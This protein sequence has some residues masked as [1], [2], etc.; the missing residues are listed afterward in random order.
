LHGRPGEVPSI[1]P[2]MPCA[3][4]ACTQSRNVWRSMPPIRA[5]ALRLTPSR[6]P[7]S[8]NSR[9]A[10]LASLDAAAA[11]LPESVGVQLDAITTKI[12]RESDLA[13]SKCR[14]HS[15]VILS[16]GWYNTAF[17]GL[18]V[19]LT[20]AT[21]EAVAMVLYEFVT[22]AVKY[23]ALSTPQGRVS[24]TWVGGSNG[25]LS[26]GIVIKWRKTGSPLATPPKRSGYGTSLIR[27]LIP[28]EIGGA[29]DLAFTA[30]GL[31]CKIK[32]RPVRLTN[33]AQ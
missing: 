7:A 21:T 12:P 6:T 29:V 26:E 10:W 27:D 14:S 4:K 18:K 19:L 24:V 2:S 13:D 8:A 9:R 17:D 30:E 20:A 15:R 32:L 33:R 1:S 3:L 28:H 5:A 16:A 31:T 25:R 11:S 22:N 23:G